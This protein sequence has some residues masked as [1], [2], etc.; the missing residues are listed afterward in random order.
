MALIDMGNVHGQHLIYNPGC[1]SIEE[2]MRDGEIIAIPDTDEGIAY[3]RPVNCTPL[4]LAAQLTVEEAKRI[5]EEWNARI[6]GE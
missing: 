1:K 3:K 4:E 5:T 6:A 2:L